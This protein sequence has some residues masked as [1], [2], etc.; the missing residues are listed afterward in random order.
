MLMYP[1]QDLFLLH[2]TICHTKAKRY[3]IF[4]RRFDMDPVE[5]QKTQQD[6]NTDPLVPVHKSVI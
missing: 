4:I 2:T 6:I 1:L 5:L 3:N